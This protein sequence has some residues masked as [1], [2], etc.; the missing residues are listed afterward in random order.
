VAD[1]IAC[2]LYV[3]P[4]PVT[5]TSSAGLGAMSTSQAGRVLSSPSLGSSPGG[6]MPGFPQSYSS[7]SI[8]GHSMSSSQ[9][10][11]LS[12]SVASAIVHGGRHP[13]GPPGASETGG[14]AWGG[15][16]AY[17]R[18]R[19]RGPLYAVAGFL[20]VAMIASALFIRARYNAERAAAGRLPA[21]TD[22]A[23]VQTPPT[24]T[25]PLLQP[26]IP[27]QPG[28]TSPTGATQPNAPQVGPAVTTSTTSA[29]TPPPAQPQSKPG[30]PTV[31][32]RPTPTPP[33]V[34]PDPKT[35]AQ[36]AQPT[37]PAKPT[38]QGGGIPD[39]RD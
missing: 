39:T 6:S 25:S 35:P 33:P 5:A 37:G 38:G 27:P 21:P 7:P 17:F 16:H 15:T 9:S 30:Q 3:P 4:P 14:A 29:V 18:E 20:V 22:T 23:L 28:A 13:S 26:Q 2:V 32:R 1:G 11:A 34:K 12:Q 8:S 19:S 24:V 10:G 31:I 36:P